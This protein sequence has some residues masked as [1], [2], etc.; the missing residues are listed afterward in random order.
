[1]LWSWLMGRM[2][3]ALI[4]WWYGDASIEELCNYSGKVLWAGCRV[5]H[6]GLVMWHSHSH[7]SHSRGIV[8]M[9]V[10]GWLNILVSSCC[11][12]I[13]GCEAIMS[14]FLL[15]SCISRV[16]GGV[17]IGAQ[18]KVGLFG[19]KLWGRLWSL[20]LLTCP[21]GNCQL[22]IGC[23]RRFSYMCFGCVV[24]RF[25]RGVPLVQKICWSLA[26]APRWTFFS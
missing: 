24:H 7:L 26:C 15:H 12:C 17:L 4:S 16:R 8:D 25:I 11:L 19:L 13:V 18:T 14:L 3:F 22:V 21:W 10:P 5:T 23:A 9:Y 6:G 2:F 20:W 1:M